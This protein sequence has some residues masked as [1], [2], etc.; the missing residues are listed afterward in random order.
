[1]KRQ[2]RVPLG[3]LQEYQPIR[4]SK[5]ASDRGAMRAKRER[6]MRTRPPRAALRR[7]NS[8]QET[9][10]K[11]SGKSYERMIGFSLAMFDQAQ[12]YRRVNRA[13]LGTSAE[14]VV[15]RGIHSVL[16][17]IIEREL[18]RELQYSLTRT[19]GT[20]SRIHLCLSADV[21]AERKTSCLAA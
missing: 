10:A 12:E 1:M 5:L 16:A 11:T 2:L 4:L 7:L 14:A 19:V 9:S 15:R 17:G 21:E 18:K 8:T 13:L 3:D 20:L 6:N